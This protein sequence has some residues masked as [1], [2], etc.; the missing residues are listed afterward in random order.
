MQGLGLL[1]ITSFFTMINPLGTIPVYI[2]LTQGFSST[3]CRR[4]VIKAIIAAFI[5]LSLLAFAG[6]WVFDFFN[7]SIN[8]LKIVGGFL[9]FNNGI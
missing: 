7:I 3:E 4:V 2:A 6:Q 9:F 1:Y 8:G 5:M